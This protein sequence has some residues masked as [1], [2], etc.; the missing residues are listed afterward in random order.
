M[1]HP[2]DEASKDLLLRGPLHR[3]DERKI[4][5]GLVKLIEV[6]KARELFGT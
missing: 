2:L 3:E 4:K 5:F 6:G 1:I